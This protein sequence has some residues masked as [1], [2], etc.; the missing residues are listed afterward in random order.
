[1]KDYIYP[2]NYLKGRKHLRQLEVCL[3][4]G[5]GRSTLWRWEKKG[6]PSHRPRGSNPIYIEEEVLDWIKSQPNLIE[7]S[8]E[9]K[10]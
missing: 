6:L 3:M 5:I 4:L 9:L 7:K 8:Y 10:G 2:Y 1:M